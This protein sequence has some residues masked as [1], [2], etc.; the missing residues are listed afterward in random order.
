MS[1]SFL[2]WAYLP[3][4]LATF[5]YLPPYELPSL[6]QL[7]VLVL[8]HFPPANLQHVLTLNLVVRCSSSFLHITSLL[9]WGTVISLEGF[10]ASFLLSIKAFCFR[11]EVP[12]CE[13]ALQRA[14]GEFSG[15]Q[16]LFQFRVMQLLSLGSTLVR[17]LRAIAC[18]CRMTAKKG[19]HWPGQTVALEEKRSSFK[20]QKFQAG[21]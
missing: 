17:W 4:L 10:L 2:P 18:R 19:R 9:H 5:L 14:D 12:N 3:F 15:D 16:N 21:P 8:I 7:F 20:R 13:P 1:W 6:Q 11:K